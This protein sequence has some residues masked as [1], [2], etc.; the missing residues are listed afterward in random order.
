MKALTHYKPLAFALRSLILGTAAL[1]WFGV[2]GFCSPQTNATCCAKPMA[3]SAGLSEGSLYQTDSKWTT[4]TGK[5]ISLAELQGRPQVVV[6]FFASC[7]SAC[8]ILLHDLKR[9][10]ASLK[11]EHRAR[12]GFTLVTIDPRRDTPQA[13]ARYRAVHRLSA[14][15]WALVRGEPDDI[16]EL[17][18]LL[19]V[20]YKEQ[21]D[22]VFAH[23][24]LITVLDQ[25]G[26]VVHQLVGLGQDIEGTVRVIEELTA[27]TTKEAE[28][29]TK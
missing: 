2:T 28:L 23:S 5:E 3:S 22:G 27:N 26:E 8:P 10:E 1:S 6:M 24:N 4:D 15:N 7:Q 13:L 11:P 14:E 16:Q 29:R 21:A 12:V 17:A 9:I 18:A 20:K 25:N 19:G